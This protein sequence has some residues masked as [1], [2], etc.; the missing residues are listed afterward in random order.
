VARTIWTAKSTVTRVCR[1]ISL[2]NVRGTGLHGFD[3]AGRCRLC[4][5]NDEDA[6]IEH[7]ATYMRESEWSGLKP[8]AMG[9]GRCNLA[10]RLPRNGG[11]G[12][13]GFGYGLST[14]RRDQ[15][16][17]GISARR[18]NRKVFGAIARTIEARHPPLAYAAHRT[19]RDLPCGADRFL[20]VRRVGATVRR[21]RIFL[22]GRT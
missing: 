17:G 13:A 6:V 14:V 1:C 4:T 22:P 15:P 16:R 11:C 19:G 2:W 5:S 10:N 3:M 12:A 20:A 8:N 21:Q 9:Q 7:V 18:T